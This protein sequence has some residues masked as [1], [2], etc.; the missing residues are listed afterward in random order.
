MIGVVVG[1]EERLAEHRVAGLAV[2]KLCQKIHRRVH[3]ELLHGAKVG[4]ESFHAL[5]PSFVR[6]WRISVGPVSIRELR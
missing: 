5:V 6:F 4:G 1:Y 2:R 3:H